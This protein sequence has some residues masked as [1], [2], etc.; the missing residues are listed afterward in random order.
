M[1]KSPDRLEAYAT[2]VYLSCLLWAETEW[3]LRQKLPRETLGGALRA[4]G[5]VYWVRLGPRKSLRD[6]SSKLSEKQKELLSAVGGL[7]YL[8]RP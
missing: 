3:R 5:D 8:P 1:R 7:E 6:W 2:V 4:L